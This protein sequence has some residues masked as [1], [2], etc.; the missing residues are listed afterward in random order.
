MRILFDA[1]FFLSFNLT[2]N[3]YIEFLLTFLCLNSGPRVCAAGKT[4]IKWR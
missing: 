1:N 3:V 4:N 2:N